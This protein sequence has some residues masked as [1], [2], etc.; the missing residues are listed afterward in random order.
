MVPQ[1]HGHT[2]TN[3]LR[4]HV[5]SPIFVCTVFL[6]LNIYI[7][8]SRII[9]TTFQKDLNLYLYLPPLSAHPPS[10]LKGL[11]NGKLCR[12]WTQNTTHEDFQDVLTKFIARLLDRGHMITA[13]APML[14]Q[15]AACLDHVSVTNINDAS[16]KTLYVHWPYHP[17]RLK[18]QKI[19]QIYNDT[20]Q[21]ALDYE[22]MQVAISR[23]KNLRDILTCAALKLPNNIDINDIIQ[24]CKRENN[25]HWISLNTKCNPSCH[26]TM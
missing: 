20:L 25:Q 6:D 21:H 5:H 3:T 24:Q 13:L 26:M 4:H 22:H 8:N 17:N 1:P 10:C 7:K 12:Y 16:S 23:P 11:I 18:W 9:T 2:M 14:L 15:A 19:R